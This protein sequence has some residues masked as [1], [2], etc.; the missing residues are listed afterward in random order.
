MPLF[1]LPREPL[2]H[3]ELTHFLLSFVFT[4]EASVTSED[5]NI[6][7]N[8]RSVQSAPL[9]H[10]CCRARAQ[11]G[12][13]ERAALT[14]FRPALT[15][16][17]GLL[18]LLRN[19]KKDEKELRILMLGLDNSG[20]TTALKQLAGVPATLVHLPSPWSVAR[21]ITASGLRIVGG[22]QSDHADAGLQHQVGAAG[23]LQAECVGHRRPEAHPAV[24][25]K[26]LPEH[27][28]ARLHD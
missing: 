3:T 20:K 12:E 4:A 8:G 26:L 19:L 22:C 2:D 27:R 13:S 10:V 17:R 14:D 23:G 1:G 18:T 9:C 15:L 5:R 24:L 16:R 25:E 28:C 21:Q 11:R 6:G 7:C